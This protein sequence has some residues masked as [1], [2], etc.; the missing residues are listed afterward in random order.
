MN[1]IDTEL[2]SEILPGLW[3][4]GTENFDVVQETKRER[5]ASITKES[6]DTVITAYAFANPASWAVK[7]IR[8]TFYDGDMSDINWEDIYQAVDIAYA[9]W[10]RGLRVLCRCQAGMNRSSL[11]CALVLMKDGYTADEAIALIRLKRSPHALFN[12]DFV[13]WLQQYTLKQAS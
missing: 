9:D 3:L 12:Q 7:E 4:G 5:L 6:F 11:I 10:K 2:Y 1:G 8:T 13:R